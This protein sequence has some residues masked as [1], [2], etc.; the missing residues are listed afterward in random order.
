MD[1]CRDLTGYATNVGSFGFSYF[2]NPAWL[3]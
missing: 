1:S 3:R 2:S